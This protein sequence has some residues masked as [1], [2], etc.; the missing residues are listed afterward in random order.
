MTERISSVPESRG[1]DI[2]NQSAVPPRQIKRGSTVS[3]GQEVSG[4]CC[5]GGGDD[6]RDS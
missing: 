4:L 2:R 3:A 5:V 1:D 6:D